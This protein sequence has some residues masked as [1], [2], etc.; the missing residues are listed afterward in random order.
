MIPF[1]WP[2]DNEVHIHC[3]PLAAGASHY[4]SS[5]EVLRADRL[6]D[7]NKRNSF[8]A[9]RGL[10]REILGGYPGVQPDELHFAVGEHGKPH[11]SGNGRLH[12]NLSHSGA[13]FILA[14]VSDREVGIDI[15]QLRDDTPVPDMARLAFSPR[16]QKEL[17]ALPDHLQRRAFY[18]CW[19]RKEAYLKAC[20][21]GFALRSNS[22]DVSL[23]QETPAV[24][25]SPDNLTK[26]TLM[27]VTVP[28]GYCAALAVKGSAPIIRYIQSA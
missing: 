3:L 5:D 7:P 17:F 22:F 13:L 1:P 12:F 24:L 6:L 19:T 16:E 2:E 11:L 18:R 27:D 20:G 21:M 8:M 28:E 25:I 4:L 23:H 10:L 15:E 9:G 26:W 14:V